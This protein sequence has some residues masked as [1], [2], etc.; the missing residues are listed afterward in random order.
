MAG[1]SLD[2]GTTLRLVGWVA[3]GIA[4]GAGLIVYVK[5]QLK[6]NTS[7]IA[8]LK[9]DNT[10]IRRQ[11]ANGVRPQDIAQVNKRIDDATN[12]TNAKLDLI[13]ELVKTKK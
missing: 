5:Q 4:Y 9:A 13:L 10:E 6:A 11:L 1:E 7:D 2:P 12:A 8:S 3:G